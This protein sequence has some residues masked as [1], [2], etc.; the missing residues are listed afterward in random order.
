MTVNATAVYRVRTGGNNANGGGFDPTISGAGTDYSQQDAAQWSSSSVT[1]SSTT[2]T[3]NNSQGTLTTAM[4]G[5][6]VWLS[7]AAYFILTVPTANTFTVD[8]A[9]TVAAVAAKIGGAWANPW[10]NLTGSAWIV[11]G[12]TIYVRGSGSD[13]PSAADYTSTSFVQLPAG[14]TSVG[15]IRLLSENGRPQINSAGLLYQ[16]NNFWWFEGFKVKL[17]SASNG[18]IIGWGGTPAGHVFKN[19]VVDQNNFD[20]PLNLDAGNVYINCI[21]Y[22][23]VAI[24]GGAGTS[25]AFD[26]S[27]NFGSTAIGCV[28]F[29]VKGIGFALVDGAA[30]INCIAANGAG[31]GVTVT[32]SRTDMPMRVIGCTID[33]NAGHGINLLTDDAVLMAVIANNIVRNHTSA[34][35]YGIFANNTRTAAV[36][37]RIKGFADY[38]DLYNNNGAAG[39]G[40]QGMSDAQPAGNSQN[41]NLDP[42]FTN[43][44]T[45]I[46]AAD[47]SIGTNLK[48]KGLPGSFNPAS[49]M[50]TVGYMDMGAVQRQEPTGGGTTIINSRATAHGRR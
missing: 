7:G 29:N 50:A 4:I 14:S 28:A 37:D 11:P 1:S 36:N 47:Y 38:N 22:S 16:S 32:S 33:A 30:A 15:R 12:C 3:D 19:V 20:C 8:R 39:G 41:L 2:C 42:Q 25:A 6:V 49:I 31:D 18:R 40:W 35:K 44:S 34:S 21:I 24:S 13:A 27:P 17:T 43:P 46:G 23:S 45:T 5:N 9:P 48:A 10:T 26:L